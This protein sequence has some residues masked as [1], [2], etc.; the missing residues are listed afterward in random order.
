MLQ[1]IVQDRNRQAEEEEDLTYCEVCDQCDREDRLLLCD[2]CD[3][4]FH[5]ECLTPPLQEV[6][7]NEW[8]CPECAQRQGL[9]FVFLAKFVLQIH[10]WKYSITCNK[11]PLNPFPPF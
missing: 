10:L 3:K 6:P 11:R 7:V 2:G 9:C 1:I 5:L 8:F 4:G